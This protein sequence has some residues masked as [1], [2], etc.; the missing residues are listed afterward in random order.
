[1]SASRRSSTRKS[2]DA[3]PADLSRQQYDE[4]GTKVI[5]TKVIDGR[6]RET[7]YFR[8]TVTVELNVMLK[9]FWIALNLTRLF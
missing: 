5:G 6:H 9:I 1:V 2:L 8:T 4:I 7:S 3:V